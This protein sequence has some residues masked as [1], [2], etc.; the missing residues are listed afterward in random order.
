MKLR[1]TSC[2]IVENGR[3]FSLSEGGKEEEQSVYEEYSFRE[4]RRNLFTVTVIRLAMV[5]CSECIY[6]VRDCKLMRARSDM[7]VAELSKRVLVSRPT[8]QLIKRIKREHILYGSNPAYT[9]KLSERTQFVLELPRI[10]P[11]SE[12]WYVVRGKLLTASNMAACLGQ[13]QYCTQEELFLKM[14]KQIAPFSGNEATRW[15]QTYEEEAGQVYSMLTGLELVEEP[16]GFLIHNYE[17]PGD[18]GRKRYGATPDFMTKGGILV[19]IKCPFR[20]KIKHSIPKYYIP[21]VQFQMEVTGTSMAHFVQYRPPNDISDGEIDI[22]TVM[23]D[24]LWWQLNLPVFDAFW[25]SVIAWYAR[26]GRE[27]G[28]R[29]PNCAELYEAEDNDDE[30]RMNTQ[31]RF[32][33]VKL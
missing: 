1:T 9:N 22:L 6:F 23:R 14:T 26:H 13:N 27:V 7:T 32:D 2:G 8:Q 24:A 16:I 15:G 33:I 12:T 30:V 31:E 29:P 28:E 10:A 21:Q 4:R 17:K 5:G 11:L 19:E 20:R 18:G 25:D 3:T